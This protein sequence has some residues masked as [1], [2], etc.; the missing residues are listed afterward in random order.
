MDEIIIMRN[1]GYKIY[2]EDSIREGQREDYLVFFP[3][4]IYWL[5]D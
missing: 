5:A 2:D 4:K 1:E 3:V